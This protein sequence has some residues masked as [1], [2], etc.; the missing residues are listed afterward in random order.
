ME[1]WRVLAMS[2]K[3]SLKAVLWLGVLESS[4]FVGQG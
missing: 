4:N 2:V 3:V 1:Y